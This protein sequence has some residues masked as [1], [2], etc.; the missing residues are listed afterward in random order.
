[1]VGDDVGGILGALK[2]LDE[3]WGPVGRD[4]ADAH[5]TWDDVCTDRLPLD[6][7]VQFVI[8]APPGTAVF[9][10]IN[11]G[12][13]AT[14]HKV[15]DLIE[16]MKISLCINAEDPKAAYEQLGRDLRPGAKAEAPQQQMTIGEYMKLA[17]LEGGE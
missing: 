16:W 1:V 17:N 10:V 14:T 5:Y 13:E 2:V 8:Y 4:L 6:Q 3:H 11:E 12:W 15:S 9:H 7:F